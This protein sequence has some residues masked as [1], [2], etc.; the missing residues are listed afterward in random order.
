[1]AV[2]VKTSGIP[3]WGI[4]EFATHFRTYFSGDWDVHLANRGF[5]PW[6]YHER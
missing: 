6:P 5:D 4:G 1:M 2:V 3:F